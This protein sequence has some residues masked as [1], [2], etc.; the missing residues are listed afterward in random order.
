M[1]QT[2]NAGTRSHESIVVRTGNLV[3]VMK[4]PSSALSQ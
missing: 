1:T 2:S 4:Q 3:V